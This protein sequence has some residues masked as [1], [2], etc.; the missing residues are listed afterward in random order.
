MR[1]ILLVLPFFLLYT[2]AG[3]QSV[4]YRQSIRDTFAVYRDLTIAKDY[5]RIM[6]YIYPKLFDL[7]GREQLVELFRGLDDD[8]MTITFVDLHIDS[9][10][11]RFLYGDEQFVLVHH[12]GKMTVRP[13]NNIA[14][15]TASLSLLRSVF[16]QQYGAKNVSLSKSMAARPTL[17]I[18]M[19]KTLFAIAPQDSRR[20]RF[21]ENN[22]DNPAMLEFLLPKAVIGRFA[23]TH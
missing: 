11:E 10:S 5:E 17:T 13:G 21:L 22:R 14:A 3:A 12:G 4:D 2:A 16:E 20:W 1:H 23:P 15:D 18:Q 7:V 6:D 19:K 8:E 9:M